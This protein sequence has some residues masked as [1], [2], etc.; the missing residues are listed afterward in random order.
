MHCPVW[1][2]SRPVVTSSMD[3]AHYTSKP[4]P[5][6]YYVYNGNTKAT[7]FNASQSSQEIHCQCPNGLQNVNTIE[8]DAKPRTPPHD[9]MPVC[10]MFC[11]V[12]QHHLLL[13]RS[14]IF[15]DH[16]IY[17]FLT[18]LAPSGAVCPSVEAVMTGLLLT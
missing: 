3:V 17:L 10:F 15:I 12:C 2:G 7:T 11:L 6:P 13:S 8:F 4:D 16:L 14:L 9:Q 18:S 5:E 1:P